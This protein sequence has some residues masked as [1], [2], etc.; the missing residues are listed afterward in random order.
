MPYTIAEPPPVIPEDADPLMGYQMRSLPPNGTLPAFGIGETPSIAEL[1]EVLRTFH[2]NDVHGSN[3]GLRMSELRNCD[4][5]KRVCIR[6]AE[7]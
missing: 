4:D 7:S 2:E 6:I 1:A 5:I 3:G